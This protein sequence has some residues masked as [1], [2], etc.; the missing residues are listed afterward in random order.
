MT[1]GAENI[2]FLKKGAGNVRFCII[3]SSSENANARKID[4][5]PFCRLNFF[6]WSSQWFFKKVSQFNKWIGIALW[7]K[8]GWGAEIL[9]NF[10]KQVSEFYNC[11]PIEAWEKDMW[12]AEIINTKSSCFY[13]IEKNMHV[14]QNY[15]IVNTTVIKFKRHSE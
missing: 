2:Q 12:R 13:Q 6:S 10:W 3:S 1:K 9:R 4:E 14:D 5:T 11:Y 8:Q 7:E 15:Q